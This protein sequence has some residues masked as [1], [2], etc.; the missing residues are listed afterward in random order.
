[1]SKC[2]ID[3]CDNNARTSNLCSTH[4]NKLRRE[5]GSKVCSVVGC[6]MSVEARGLCYK[7][8]WEP[9]L[10][11]RKL[12]RLAEQKEENLLPFDYEQ[13]LDKLQMRL[14]AIRPQNPLGD[15]GADA[16]TQHRPEGLPNDAQH[17]QKISQ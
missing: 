7:H 8:Y 12:A 14:D 16:T 13:L 2:R 3:G 11:N 17:A 4:Y 10:I 15:A 6:T 5:Q 9:I 1:M